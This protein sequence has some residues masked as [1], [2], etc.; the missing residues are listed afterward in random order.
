M[1]LVAAIINRL[2]GG[3]KKQALTTPQVE[4][5]VFEKLTPNAAQLEIMESVKEFFE[6]T[7][8]ALVGFELIH[9]PDI[10]KYGPHVMVLV[11]D[12]ELI[13]GL[14]LDYQEHTE[15]LWTQPWDED[16]NGEEG[17]E[18]AAKTGLTFARTTANVD[19]LFGQTWDIVEVFNLDEAAGDQLHFDAT[20][21]W[22]AKK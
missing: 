20:H 10:E 12:D 15:I 7:N 19:I 17:R 13:K 11:N 1:G 8:I 21:Y 4:T 6:G 22:I 2:F 9:Y 18:A 14:H 16:Q 3:K 5:P